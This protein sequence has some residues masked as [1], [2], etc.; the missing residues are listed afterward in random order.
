MLELGDIGYAAPLKVHSRY[1]LETGG[2]NVICERLRIIHPL[3]DVEISEGF[4]Y[5]HGKTTSRC[6]D[7]PKTKSL[8][9]TVSTKGECWNILLSIE[10]RSTPILLQDRL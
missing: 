6:I 3:V 10:G 1:I 8:I 7:M 5:S 2:L 9:N 4:I